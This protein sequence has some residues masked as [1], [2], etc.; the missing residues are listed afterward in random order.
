[1]PTIDYESIYKRSLSRMK[2]TG[3]AQYDELDFYDIL[4]EWLSSA[5]ADPLLRKKF[6]KFI[7]DEEEETIE[8][9]LAY[10][11]DDMYDT[12]FVINILAQGLVLNYFA[13]KLEDDSYLNAIVYG[14]E[15]KW[16]DNYKNAQARLEDLT[17]KYYRELSQ[18]G[19]YFQRGDR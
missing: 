18:H 12:T 16:K 8:F 9:E 13:H 4:K 3:L 7:N 6:D 5:M 15:E 2:D 1:M 19:Y 14:K 10:K 17:R 11:T